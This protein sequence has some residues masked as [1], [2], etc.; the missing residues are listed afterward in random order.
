MIRTGTELDKIRTDIISIEE[1]NRNWE[2]YKVEIQ[3][4][5]DKSGSLYDIERIKKC[6]NTGECK[7]FTINENEGYFVIR[8]I[9]EDKGKI[10]EAVS[11]SGTI[12]DGIEGHLSFILDT[13]AKMNGCIEWIFE[14]RQGWIKK[15]RKY[16][17]EAQIMIRVRKRIE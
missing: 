11:Y 1:V 2:L 8:I 13:L 12:G 15:L 6:I 5:L 9:T 7:L 10:L 3:R 17:P 14:G 16:V 4:A